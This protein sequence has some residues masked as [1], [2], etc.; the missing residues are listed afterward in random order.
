MSKKSKTLLIGWDAA[1]WEII[2]PL[3][4]KGE[5]PALKKVISKGVYGNMATMNPP[6]S[7]M[8]WSSVATGK[9]PDKHGV[10]GFLEI[11][12][13][14]KGISPVTVNSRKTKAIWNILHNKGFKSNIVGWWPSFPAEPINGVVVTD[15]FQTTNQDPEKRTPLVKGSIHPDELTQ[16]MKDL[17]M[18][19]YEITEAH[20]LPFIPDASKIDQDKDK[21]LASFAKLMAENI[22]IHCAATNLM[23]TTEWDFMAIYYNLIDHFC[24]AFMK[25]H[26]PKLDIVPE[27]MYNI[28]KHCIVGAYKFQ[29]MMLQR[30]LELID[31]DTTVIIMSD[32]GFE[33]GTK[34]I[35][36]MPKISAAPALDHRQF[37]MF[38]AAGPN[39]KTNE[40][41][42]G[43]SLLD[44]A[45]TVLHMFDLPIGEDMDGRPA[46]DIFKEPQTPKFI[47]SWENIEGD[48]GERP[49]SEINDALDDQEA[50]KQLIELGY[51]EKPDDKIEVAILKTRCDL[52]FNLA[53]V[54][55]GKRDFKNARPILKS[56]IAEKD[57]I[58]V[59]P[60]YM[61]LLSI[62][63]AEKDIENAQHY[64][65]EIKAAKPS[66]ELKL[67]FFEAD[68]LLFKGQTKKALQLLHEEAKS[69]PNSELW[70][71]IGS[72]YLKLLN[73]EEAKVS[74]LKGLEIEAD[75]A[76]LNC[77]LA[78]AYLGLG[79]YEE[80]ADYAIT[81][82]ELVRF[83]PKAHYTLG[84]ALEN[85][86]DIDA[87]K[88]AYSMAKKLKPKT[89]YKAQKAIEN[90][91]LK[92]SE[93]LDK[94]SN[95][96]RYHKDQIVIVS[97]LP[98]SGTSLM[99]QML[100]KGGLEVL[101]DKERKADISNPKGYFEYKPVMQLHKDND[102][103]GLAQNKG[104]K[105]VAPLLKF[106]N[107]KYRYKIIFMKR[108][109][110]EIM[111]SQNKMLGKDPDSFSV[112]LEATFK[113]QLNQVE[114]WKKLQ[115]GVELIY[116][117]YKETLNTP[118]VV[119]D[120]LTAFT[121]LGLNKDA[122]ASCIDK[123][124]YR[125]QA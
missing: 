31:D 16:E 118:E 106:L 119:I 6:Y 107:P 122:M 75:R 63:I 113:K 121:G 86:G 2:W 69:R 90:L 101:T 39:I 53:R 88:T 4:A 12:P 22:S 70:H 71:K 56:L 95:N 11:K 42:F 5:M 24:H 112:D 111:K 29:D 84:V 47:D 25:F 36:K 92:S 105:V 72:I 96:T 115:P 40:K 9:T 7:P 98:R 27:E 55:M 68:I 116:I 73:F 102:W 14:L 78:E 18:F 52:Q 82:I 67:H 17:R 117:D 99:M 83:F 97:G 44:I 41:V 124:L 28:Y 85:L 66:Y 1:D 38:V 120:K 54:Y 65:E 64:L 21:R 49:K 103:L 33:S 43:L 93:N 26:P 37:G 46:L 15:R 50:M 30:K 8:L 13:D 100:D 19:S 123:T 125:T 10:L 51:I 110:N 35:T 80:A 108:D 20:I 104:L 3:I 32:H 87:A 60:F 45:P 74:F 81:A 94:K 89:Y 62:S 79:E 57:P 77:G 48:F 109:L 59:V 34:R 58:D 114:L 23:R 76:K 61:A 91:E